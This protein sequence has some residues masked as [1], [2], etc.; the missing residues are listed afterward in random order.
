[1]KLADPTGYLIHNSSTSEYGTPVG[2]E[3]GREVDWHRRNGANNEPQNSFMDISP[4]RLEV[5]PE[6]NQFEWHVTR[7]NTTLYNQVNTPIEYEKLQQGIASSGV[8]D[9]FDKAEQNA[10]NTVSDDWMNGLV[11]PG[12]MYEEGLLVDLEMLHDSGDTEAT[13]EDLKELDG[14]PFGMPALVIR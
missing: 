11:Y 4:Y 7:H 6:G 9:T 13:I 12:E 14:P 3:L 10:M 5:R 2:F 8:C 1:M